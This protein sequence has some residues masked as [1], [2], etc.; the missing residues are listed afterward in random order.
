MKKLGEF[1]D[2]K[3]KDTRF[4]RAGQGHSLQ[5]ERKIPESS[6]ASTTQVRRPPSQGSQQAGTAALQRFETE[7]KVS[8]KPKK[9]LSIWKTQ[10]KQ[11]V[12][13]EQE[14]AAAATNQE[15][16]QNQPTPAQAYHDNDAPV[17][18]TGIFY[19]CPLCSTAATQKDLPAHMEDCFLTLV[20]ADPIQ[21]SCTMIN[22]LNRDFEKL[23]L[24]KDTLCKYIDNVCNNPG[25]EKY[26]KIRVGNKAF[27]ERVCS[28]KGAIEYLQAVG[29]Q[30]KELP[31]QDVP[32]IFWVLSEEF[33]TNMERLKSCKES[34]QTAETIR[35]SLS[36]D[37]KILKPQSG[38]LRFRL[39]DEFFRITAEE[40]KREQEMRRDV[41]EKSE[42]LRTRAMK[43][44]DE[45][46]E[47]RQYKYTVIR[48]RF[49]DDHVL[50]GTFHA[51]DKLSEVT[52]FVRSALVNDWQPFI[53]SD[54]TGPL[55]EKEDTSLL[56]LKLAP[57]AQ[58]TFAWDPQIMAE[59]AAAQ[60]SSEMSSPLKPEL[61]ALCQTL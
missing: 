13:R 44:A 46:N 50:Q 27:Q 45:Q 55:V 47:K 10:I 4:K 7:Q 57:A 5:E 11:E 6:S 22:S 38:P 58:L 51:R 56:Q 39:P 60:G 17:S 3:K 61:I 24:G 15:R 37:M 28:L 48:V 33:A 54:P 12:E 2:K 14:A 29:F 23:K 32:E 35:P 52:D 43:A 34:L 9:E 20:S 53:L 16:K 49:A 18:V 21:G 26:L 1:I 40:A 8:Q 36:R 31:H 41:I 19:Q 59:I 30:Q 42:Q 25:E